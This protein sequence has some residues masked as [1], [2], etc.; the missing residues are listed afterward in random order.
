[1]LNILAFLLNL[2]D[3]HAAWLY[4]ICF[5]LILLSVRAY[6]LAHQS[7]MNT[8]FTIEREV[9]THKEGQAM[10]NIGS[11]LGIVIVLTAVKYYLI[12]GIDVQGLAE[13][14]P[15][16]TLLIPTSLPTPMAEVS[17]ASATPTATPRPRRTLR[18]IITVAPPTSTPL[19]PAP[20]PDANVRITSPRMGAMLSG[21]VVVQ[22]TASH[23]R[24][25]FYKVEI[26]HG[27]QPTSWT[28][29]NETHAAPVIGGVLEQFDTTR[30][31]NGLY[32]LQL[33]VVDQSGNFPPPCQV[34]VTIQN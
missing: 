7:R 27:A 14:T 34:R 3:Q 10:T 23:A 18:P 31:P 9:A 6:L 1:V 20:C 13:P 5:A 11:I 19:P 30:V 12:P 24:F 26:G 32:W 33:V 25:Q 4:T 22:G 28:V 21:P 15:T 8:I 2:V 17:S 29:L 16:I